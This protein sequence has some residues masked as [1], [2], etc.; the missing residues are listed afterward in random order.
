MTTYIPLTEVLKE[1]RSQYLAYA[2]LGG[3]VGGLFGF[4]CSFLYRRSRSMAQ[5]LR[6]AIAKDKLRVIYQPI[7]NLAS[8]RIE[9]AEALVR[10]TDEDGFAV[11]PDVFVKLAE[12]RGFVGTI[13]ELVVRHV[14][15]DFGPTLCNDQCFRVSVNV[16]A[17]DLVDPK[18]LPMLERALGLAG[19]AAES[20]TIEITEGNTVRNGAAIETI[21][22]LRKRG[23]SVHIDDFGTGYSSLSYLHD[24]SVDAIKIDK[25]FTQSIGTGAVIGS[26]LPQILAIAE[27]L[28][29]DVT[30]EGI[31][32]EE[33]ASYFANT[34]AQLLAQGWLFGHPVPADEFLAGLAASEQRALIAVGEY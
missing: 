1:R 33:Q 22:Q 24:L 30:V 32:T 14:L 15:C 16:A 29:L 10:W 28:N 5:Q 20:L 9:G 21:A 27:A 3:I 12:E 34:D 2:Y 19:V 4:V 13:T 6:R 18:F 25:S 11:G 31:E 8:R 7:V 23:H 17:A 26:I